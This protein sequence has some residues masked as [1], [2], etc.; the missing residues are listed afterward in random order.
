MT[1]QK[2]LVLTLLGGMLVVLPAV[3]FFQFLHHKKSTRDLARADVALMQK[4]ELGNVLNFHQALNVAINRSLKKGDMDIYDE[5]V[6][7]QG[8]VSGFAEF[9]LYNRSGVVAYSSDKKSLKKSIDPEILRKLTS[10]TSELVM[11]NT[12][13]VE[14]YSPIVATAQCMECHDDYK[15]EALCGVSYFRMSNDVVRLAEAQINDVTTSALRQGFSD[16]LI[17]FVAEAGV[18]G[19]FTLLV[20]RSAKMSLIRVSGKIRERSLDLEKTAGS[21]ASASE[22]IAEGASEQAASLEET[23]SVL[24]ELSSRSKESARS[25]GDVNE[26]AKAAREAAACGLKDMDRMTHAMS[27]IRSATTGI[28]SIIK[29]IDE[30]AFQ[31]NLLALNAAVEAAR[32]GTAGAGFAVVAD[33]VR[34]L[35]QR[36]AASARETSTQIEAAVSRTGLGVEISAQVSQ[37]LNDIAQKVER[38]TQLISETAASSNEQCQG[39]A[40]VSTAVSEIDKVTQSNAA[41]AEE[42]ASAAAELKG[43]ATALKEALE[44]L[45]SLVETRN[46]R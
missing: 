18:L 44:D 3:Q 10:Q 39:V 34:S 23:S 35:A 8:R 5:L 41:G 45:M 12:N 9:S 28:Q 22:S 15:K 11:A 16:S 26:L 42:S 17:A 46:G 43:E 21:L 29:T 33:E 4:R 7:L 24:E 27:E 2:K 6:Q 25:A 37:R 19:I 1:I 40:Q 20:G 32:V 13:H 14:I 36:S 31:T 38:V 30:I